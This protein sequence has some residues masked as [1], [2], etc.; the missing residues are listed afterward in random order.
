MKL[1]RILL[2]LSIASV[3]AVGCKSSE[4]PPPEA[5]PASQPAEEKPADA[6]ADQAAPAEGA[7]DQAAPQR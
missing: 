2:A 3:L 7:G 1:V 6:P 4:T 5:A